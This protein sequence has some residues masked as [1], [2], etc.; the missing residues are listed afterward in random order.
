MHMDC[1]ASC[2]CFPVILE[3]N[4]FS[5]LPADTFQLPTKMTRELSRIFISIKMEEIIISTNMLHI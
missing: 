1:V 3:T 4:V 5:P 2:L